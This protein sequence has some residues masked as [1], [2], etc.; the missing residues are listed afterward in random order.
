VIHRG[1]GILTIDQL[2]AL[3]SERIS[4]A[5]NGAAAVQGEADH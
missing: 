1:P 5:Q 3:L 4:N 2:K